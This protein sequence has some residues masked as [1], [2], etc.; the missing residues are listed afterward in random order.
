MPGL[1]PGIHSRTVEPAAGVTEWIAGSSPAMTTNV[2]GERECLAILPGRV[3]KQRGRGALV[4]HLDSCVCGASS[5]PRAA[6]IR[7]NSSTLPSA[8]IRRPRAP[9]A[10]GEAW[11]R[12]FPRR[13]AAKRHPAK[14]SRPWVDLSGPAEPR[15]SGRYDTRRPL[16]CRS[17][18]RSRRARMVPV[19]LRSPMSSG[20]RS[21]SED[22]GG[23]ISSNVPLREGIPDTEMFNCLIAAS[24][25]P[26]LAEP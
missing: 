17:F 26:R 13:H 22:L 9:P 11:W 7:P 21:V 1:D 20:E 3:M 2:V 12:T 19:A 18:R 8:G 4:E 6:F 25:P 14:G 10:S 16:V 5:A 23:G 15:L 24:A